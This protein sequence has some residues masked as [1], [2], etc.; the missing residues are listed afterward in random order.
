MASSDLRERLIDAKL[1]GQKAPGH[2][3]GVYAYF[4]RSNEQAADKAIATLR[5]QPDEWRWTCEHGMTTHHIAGQP[6]AK[7]GQEPERWIRV[8]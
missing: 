4:F 7:C 2:P 6:C 3:D 5:E 8:S 1:A